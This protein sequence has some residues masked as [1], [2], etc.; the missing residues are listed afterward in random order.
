MSRISIDPLTEIDL[1]ATSHQTGAYN[2]TGYGGAQ[3]AVCAEV[4]IKQNSRFLLLWT[5]SHYWDHR[6]L[7]AR[8]SARDCWPNDELWFPARSRRAIGYVSGHRQRNKHLQKS[9]S[10]PV[11]NYLLGKYQKLLCL[12]SF[13]NCG[14]GRDSSK[15][16][17]A[18]A[19]LGR[20]G[21]S[22]GAILISNVLTESI[23]KI[24]ARHARALQSEQNYTNRR[25]S[26][27]KH[28][29]N[30]ERVSTVRCPE[31]TK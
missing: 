26:H 4:S 12:W 6:S 31:H 29:A 15:S 30:R 3:F 19:I 11:I 10:L 22:H 14:P 9:Y 17:R 21:S 28:H 5:V 2:A 20:S 8:N 25:G 7:L 18:A 24:R 16:A 13:T 23:H 27:T 1:R